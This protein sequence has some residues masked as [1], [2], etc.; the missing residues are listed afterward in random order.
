MAKKKSPTKKSPP[1]FE[2]ALDQLKQCLEALES[3]DLTLD[4]SLEQY[5]NGVGH[6]KH[7]HRAIAAAKQ[8]IEK[9][10]KID[11]DGN[12]IIESF[13]NT[14]SEEMTSGTRRSTSNQKTAAKVSQNNE[15]ELDEDMDDPDGLF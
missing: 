12:A 9:L 5:E 13:D 14:A 15:D 2:V 7:C 3:E 6:L 1:T 11:A 4:Q 10:V 8:K